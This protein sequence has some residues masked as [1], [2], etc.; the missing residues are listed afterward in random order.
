MKASN[1]DGTCCFGGAELPG[2]LVGAVKEI[3]HESFREL[4]KLIFPFPFTRY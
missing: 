3:N 1:G 4:Q 2:D